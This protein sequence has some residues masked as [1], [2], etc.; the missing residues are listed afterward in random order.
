MTFIISNLITIQSIKNNTK[1][2]LPTRDKTHPPQ[3]HR[4]ITILESIFT[5][6]NSMSAK[7]KSTIH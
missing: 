1:I 7:I 6:V 4:S 5:R 2:K 3:S